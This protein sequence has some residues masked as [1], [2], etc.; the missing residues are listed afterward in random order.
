MRKGFARSLAVKPGGGDKA[1][2][3][4]AYHVFDEVPPSS[5]PGLGFAPR[6]AQKLALARSHEARLHP[7]AG[8]G[9]LSLV[10]MGEAM[11]EHLDP[12]LRPAPQPRGE[13]RARNDRSI[14]PMVRNDQHGEALANVRREQVHQSVDLAIEARRNVVN[15]REQQAL[16]TGGGH[17]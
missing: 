10:A 2:D 15:R 4:A 5:D 6:E 3:R 12:L 9:I 11:E 16:R 1:V 13:S 14:A 8:A 7:V 17:V